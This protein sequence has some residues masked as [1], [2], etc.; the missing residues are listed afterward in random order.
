ME[1]GLNVSVIVIVYT[2]DGTQ[3][4][5]LPDYFRELLLH[6]DQRDQSL[7]LLEIKIRIHLRP[8]LQ[9]I[10]VKWLLTRFLLINAKAAVLSLFE[11]YTLPPDSL[12]PLT[13]AFEK[14][15]DGLVYQALLE[16]FGG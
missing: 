2:F 11:I 15:L 14:F 10:I 6:V 9:A 3:D 13:P 4:I 1:H 12:C 8:V 16:G 7:P 5:P